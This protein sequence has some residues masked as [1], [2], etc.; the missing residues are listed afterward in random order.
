MNHD[1]NSLKAHFD[2]AQKDQLRGFG[3]ERLG[4]I[5]YAAHVI[6]R[7]QPPIG[8]LILDVGCA[9]GA[10]ME[11]IRL[12]RPDLSIDGIDLSGVQ[13]LEAKVKNPMST[14]WHG[15]I[16]EFSCDKTYFGIYTFSVLQYFH[17]KAICGLQLKLKSLIS[18]S[19]SG[20]GRGGG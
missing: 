9:D 5:F 18:S 20:R 6:N 11:S 2:N 16:M 1:L 12:L 13:I 15:D 4:P 10:I 17:P 3:S 8:A 7:L 19:P 14:L